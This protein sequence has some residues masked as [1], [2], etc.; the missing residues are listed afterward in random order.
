MA[1][2]STSRERY[3]FANLSEP[4]E[5]PDL[6]AV[7][8]ESFEWFLNEGLAETFRDISPI[9]DFSEALQLELEFEPDDEDLLEHLREVP[10]VQ[11]R[12]GLD[13]GRQQRVDQP[14]VEVEAG[15]VDRARC[16]SAA[17]AARRSRSGTR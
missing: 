17:P 4:L 5:L 2:R 15:L 13:A 14:V 12:E 3:S 16:R 6:I 10:V 11:R 7:Q 9:K 8:R 1:S